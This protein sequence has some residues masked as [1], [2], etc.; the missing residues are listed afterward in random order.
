MAN[1]STRSISG[2]ELKLLGHFS[3]S[4]LLVLCGDREEEEREVIKE[5][6]RQMNWKAWLVQFSAVS[7][8]LG[9]PVG[10]FTTCLA[11]VAGADWEFSQLQHNGKIRFPALAH[12]RLV[13]SHG[14]DSISGANDGH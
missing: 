7:V 10:P 11:R 4:Y 8:I 14:N 2:A 6:C 12:R 1:R 3:G 5:L 13:F 9:N